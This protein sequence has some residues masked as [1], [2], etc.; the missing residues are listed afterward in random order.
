MEI[1]KDILKSLGAEYRKTLN[2]N[3]LVIRKPEDDRL[4]YELDMIMENRI[5]GLLDIET[6]MAEGKEYLYY[7]ISSMPPIT[8]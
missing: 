4:D 1:K 5:Y 6:R 8:V 7:E 2:H 3:Y